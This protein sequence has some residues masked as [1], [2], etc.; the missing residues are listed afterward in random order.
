[1]TSLWLPATGKVYLPPSTPVAR[2]QSTDEYI[3]RTDIYYHANSDRLL[4]VGHPYFDVRDTADNSKILVPKVSGNQ[5][6]AFRLLLPDPNRFALVDM[7]IYNPEKERLVW[8]CRGLEIGRGQPLGVGTTGHPLFNKVKD[9][10]N[11]NNYIVTSKDDRQDTS[12]DPKQVQMFIIGCTPC[13]GEYWDAA[14][15]C[16][17]DAGQGKCP[18]LELINSVIQDG[19]MID[20]G[21][22]NI[23]N[24]TLSVNRSDV[25][26][27]I[28]NDICKYPDF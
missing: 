20:I 5:Y 6:R 18:P 23:N 28:V 25:S 13:M 10:E 2:V 15:P 26:L 27:D 21:F 17:A 8:A 14:K 1:M 4:T 22:G 16:D 3:Q 12:F 24:K 19:D 9:T 7:N 11:A